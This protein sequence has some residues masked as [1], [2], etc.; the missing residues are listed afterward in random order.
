VRKKVSIW[1]TIGVVAALVIYLILSV[2]FSVSH[3]ESVDP[4]L[5]EPEAPVAKKD[6]VSEQDEGKIEVEDSAVL[7]QTDEPES[8]KGKEEESMQ[9][10][11]ET[12]KEMAVPRSWPVRKSETVN[13]GIEGLR[14]PFEFEIGDS[15]NVS[16]LSYSGEQMPFSTTCRAYIEKG[17]PAS[18]YSFS[19]KDPVGE[20]HAIWDLGGRFL[21]KDGGEVVVLGGDNAS[22][23]PKM[24]KDSRKAGDE[25]VLEVNDVGRALLDKYCGAMGFQS[26]SLQIVLPGKFWAA[27]YQT[28]NKVAVDNKLMDAVYRPDKDVNWRLKGNNGNYSIIIQK[29]DLE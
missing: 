9:E 24:M 23:G 5:A 16:G 1:S 4:V 22:L 20:M 8:E 21:L 10:E 25:L 17:N 2:V 14:A 7:Y 3:K 18:V 13:G 26:G 15:R 27:V 28:L 6:P 29:S 12:V 19:D 11:T